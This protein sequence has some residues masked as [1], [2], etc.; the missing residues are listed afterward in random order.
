[1]VDGSRVV[2]ATLNKHLKDDFEIREESDG[3]SA[4]QT[5]MLDA[6]LV[7][8]ISGIHTPRLE[9]HDLVAR[10]RASPMRRL[11]EIPFALITSDVDNKAE[12]EFD[13]T[14]GVDGFINK[15]M[16]KAEV[17]EYLTNM[18]DSTVFTDSVILPGVA[19]EEAPVP[20]APSFEPLFNVPQLL[21]RE[22]FRQ[23]ISALAL[24]DPKLGKVC[25]LV[26]GIDNR[27]ALTASFGEEAADIVASRLA[28]LLASKVGP[29]D[30][31]GRCQGEQLAIISNGVD[32]EQ[33]VRFAQRVCK[34]LASGQ[35]TIRG[36]KFK[37]T[38]SVGVA[39]NISDAVTTGSDLLALA[40]K[41]LNQ[42]RV[43]GGNSV[44]SESRPN[45]PLFCTDHTTSK[46]IDV[47][48]LRGTEHVASNIGNLGLRILPLL[49][50]MDQELALGL[51]LADIKKQ[52]QQ[53]AQIEG[54]V[55]DAAE[56]RRFIAS[57]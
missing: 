1:M 56:G 29:S 25:A 34:G 10:L 6:S 36:K 51:P 30:A 17:V 46:L 24:P 35:I 53:R 52:L 33:G 19:K 40:E 20:V 12:R 41:R 5:L 4:W 48:N 42:A 54:V 32:L 22:Q 27:D 3:E 18:L 8:V 23:M 44:A 39:S 55:V 9:A 49:Q 13:R 15:S 11:R 47:L 7:A 28:G 37:L 21:D 16:G 14:V 45:C 50:I 38:A 2:R 26:F 43:C 57:T 31:I